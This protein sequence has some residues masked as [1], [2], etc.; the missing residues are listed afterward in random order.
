MVANVGMGTTLYANY[1]IWADKSD[2]SV[3]NV[4][5]KNIHYEPVRQMYTM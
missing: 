5:S 1:D 2:T 4:I 3:Y